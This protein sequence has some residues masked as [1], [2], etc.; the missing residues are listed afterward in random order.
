M[1]KWIVLS[2]WRRWLAR[3]ALGM[4]FILTSILT[5][6]LFLTTGHLV[7]EAFNSWADLGC[8]PLSLEELRGDITDSTPLFMGVTSCGRAYLARSL[9]DAEKPS[10]TPKRTTYYDIWTNEELGCTDLN[11]D[12][13][14]R[15]ALSRNGKNL[16]MG[17]EPNG[18]AIRHSDS[19]KELVGISNADGFAQFWLNK[20][21]N[22]ALT[23][24]DSG[25]AIWDMATGKQLSS[26][27]L[28]R[29]KTSFGYCD[30]EGHAK[31]LTVTDSFEIWNE[32]TGSREFVL[33]S[34][35]SEITQNWRAFQFSPD[36]RRLAIVGEKNVLVWSLEDGNLLWT[37]PKLYLVCTSKIGNGSTWTQCESGVAFSN[38]ARWLTEE[39]CSSDPVADWVCSWNDNLSEIIS[40]WFPMQDLAILI[41]LE[42]GRT[43]PGL[44]AGNGVVFSEDNSRMVTF[45]VDGRYEWS[46]PP[47]RQWFTPWA[48]AALGAWLSLVAIWWRLRKQRGLGTVAT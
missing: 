12:G 19:K 15:P 21:S 24:T 22:C 37:L 20:A 32:E 40:R 42:T 18:L 27:R 17:V 28:P 3:W 5:L 43:W 39:Y 35:S 23:R 8:S 11:I 30:L 7:P 33:S 9:R 29:K 36:C 34:K 25:G 44:P 26:F 6:T 46:V 14:M 45:G 13:F 16:L 47:R 41:D 1:P 2:I 48:W 31:C 38:N 4:A 10:A